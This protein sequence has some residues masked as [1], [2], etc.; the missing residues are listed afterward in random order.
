L[1]TM[2]QQARPGFWPGF[3]GP[4]PGRAGRPV[5]PSLI[6]ALIRHVCEEIDGH[7]FI[8][9]L[10]GRPSSAGPFTHNCDITSDAPVIILAS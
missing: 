6:R 9:F 8:F 10:R 3:T 5:W 7:D 2:A 1:S 4:G